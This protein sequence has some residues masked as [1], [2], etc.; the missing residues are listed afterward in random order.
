MK[1]FF[2]DIL[3]KLMSKETE[4]TFYGSN[5]SAYEWMQIHAT[6]VWQFPVVEAIWEK[7]WFLETPQMAICSAQWLSA[8][9][10]D[11]DNPF[12]EP[13]TPDAGGGPPLV[14]ETLHAKKE[15]CQSRISI[16]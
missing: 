16:I 3:L 4:L 12:F 8:F 1:S 15:P 10:Y 2:V 14:F 9:L 6:L 11:D 5:A 7:W 13:W